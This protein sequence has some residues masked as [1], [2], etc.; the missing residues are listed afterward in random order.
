MGQRFCAA[1]VV[2]PGFALER[3][4]TTE[5]VTTL[6]I[7]GTVR[8]RACPECGA[9]SSRVHSRYWRKLGD[10]PLAGRP[11]RITL[12]ARRFRCDAPSCRR[13]I[14]AERFGEA[15]VLPWARRT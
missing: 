10:L 14:F 11:V 2:P 1:T 6:V 5:T 7:R 4:D 12:R 15:I 8:C 3:V 9:R 13:R